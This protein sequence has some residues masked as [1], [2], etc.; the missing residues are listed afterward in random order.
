ML[1]NILCVFTKEYKD[2]TMMLELKKRMRRYIK[3]NCGE[4]E[5]IDD[6]ID[7]LIKSG[8]QDN[9]TIDIKEKNLEKSLKLK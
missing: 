2:A 7:R 6:K 3:L 4:T 9:F 8:Y 1:K 5:S